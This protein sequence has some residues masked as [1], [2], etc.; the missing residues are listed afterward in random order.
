MSNRPRK[1]GNLLK[2]IAGAAGRGGRKKIQ[3]GR[4]KMTPE[5][6]TD[7][8]RRNI[9]RKREL[10]NEKENIEKKP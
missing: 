2:M 4:M 7:E 1:C 3:Q 9:E 10:S 8:K 5:I 6:Q